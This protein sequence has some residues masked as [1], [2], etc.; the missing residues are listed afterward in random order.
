MDREVG[1][2]SPHRD[3][4]MASTDLI[5]TVP[6][7]DAEEFYKRPRAK[8]EAT[9][10][11]SK[12]RLSSAWMSFKRSWETKRL[13]GDVSNSGSS[14]VEKCQPTVA[15]AGDLNVALPEYAGT[16]PGNHYISDA[17]MRDPGRPR[18]V[19]SLLFR[20]KRKVSNPDDD[21]DSHVEHESD[22][23]DPG[24]SGDS[25]LSSHKRESISAVKR[26]RFR[27]VRS[28]LNPP[29]ANTAAY[30]AYAAELDDNSFNRLR[31][32][33]KEIASRRRIGASGSASLVNLDHSVDARIGGPTVSAL[34]I[35]D[36]N[37]AIIGEICL[38]DFADGSSEDFDFLDDPNADYAS[39]EVPFRSSR[40]PSLKMDNQRLT[41]IG[42]ESEFQAFFADFGLD[43][44]LQDVDAPEHDLSDFAVS[45]DILTEWDDAAQHHSDF[46]QGWITSFTEPPDIRLYVNEF[47]RLRTLNSR[48]T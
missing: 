7:E 36:D 45:A 33:T 5:S 16:P 8:S 23:E 11:M 31:E 13:N 12:G 38:E 3:D 4:V 35:G 44:I 26:A 22:E 20:R 18:K 24:G 6:E 28:Q 25:W 29:V 34:P 42:N 14:P 30:A 17:G 2:R 10:E 46:C 48:E 32:F 37:D 47:T 39:S 41:W 21:S 27:R 1:E 15:S 40:R 9:S 43:N 19:V